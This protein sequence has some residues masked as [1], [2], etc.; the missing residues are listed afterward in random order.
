ML[1]VIIP[2]LN[3]QN[4]LPSLLPELGEVRL[5]I[6]D[7]GSTDMTL[8]QALDAGA[9]LA[10]GQVGRGGQMA[11]GAELAGAVDEVTAYLFLHADCHLLSGWQSVVERA[12][13][14]PRTAWYFRYQPHGTGRGVTWLRFI[15]WLQ[16]WA[17]RLPYGDQG[18]LIPRDMYEDLGGYDQDKPLF[19]DVDIVDRIKE[20][21]GRRALQKLPIALNTDISDHLNQGVWTRGWRNYKLLKAYR[22]GEP[23]TELLKRYI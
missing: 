22:R 16:G 20:K 14:T 18:L 10:R 12:L 7:G 1:A 3:A 9:V 2:T 21:Y 6:S 13:Q 11:R 4:C 23:V 15:V 8:N 17:W 5:V 19:E